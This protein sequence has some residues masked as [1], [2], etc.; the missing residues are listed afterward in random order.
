MKRAEED[1]YKNERIYQEKFTQ[2]VGY[3][4]YHSF[5]CS[6]FLPVIILVTSKQTLHLKKEAVLRVDGT[7]IK[8]LSTKR[9]E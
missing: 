8:N 4:H 9:G 1:A 3:L 7:E 2:T 5:G 6:F